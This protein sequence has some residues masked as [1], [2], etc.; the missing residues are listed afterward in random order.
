MLFFNQSSYL[1]CNFLEYSFNF[2]KRF[3]PDLSFNSPNTVSF[4]CGKLLKE[5]ICKLNKNK[6]KTKEEAIKTIKEYM[7]FYNKARV[8]LKGTTPY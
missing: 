3:L 5:N 1:A 8:N 6:F 7:E 2:L 4:K